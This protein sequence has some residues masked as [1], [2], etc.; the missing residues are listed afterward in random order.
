MLPELGV[1][2][3]N[4]PSGRPELKGLIE[5]TF[6]AV[7]NGAIPS[8]PGH[9]RKDRERG[10]PDPRR[11]AALTLDELTR[12]FIGVVRDH[13]RQWM[14][15]YP[16]DYPDMIRDQVKPIPLELW[17]W[18]LHNRPVDLQV[19]VIEV[20][21]RGVLPRRDGLVTRKGV[22]V[23][24]L[25]Y[26]LDGKIQEEWAAK[27]GVEGTWNVE[28]AYEPDLVDRVFVV[29]EHGHFIRADLKGRFAEMYRGWTWNEVEKRQ[30]ALR[31]LRRTAKRAQLERA[32]ATD[33]VNEYIARKARKETRRATAGT[34]LKSRV[35]N[36]RANREQE[37]RGRVSRPPSVSQPNIPAKAG[38]GRM[39]PAA[40]WEAL[41]RHRQERK[42]DTHGQ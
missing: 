13:N 19:P 1:E 34:S 25:I 39:A 27:A 5:S 16:I 26:A 30:K 8:L 15:H 9:V 21:Q 38:P 17:I 3:D 22:E 10:D 18:G 6:H 28:V 12:I 42:E 2:V 35:A 20:A 36:M 4:K 33:Q 23:S 37:R 11:D 40:D 24:G 29:T 41:A 7:E 32:V 14:D 31:E